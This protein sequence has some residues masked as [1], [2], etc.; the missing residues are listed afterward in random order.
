MSESSTHKKYMKAYRARKKQEQES[1][2]KEEQAW[3][4]RRHSTVKANG[5]PTTSHLFDLRQQLT[6]RSERIA[7]TDD[8]RRQKWAIEE[9]LRSRGELAPALK[10]GRIDNVILYNGYLALYQRLGLEEYLARVH[11]ELLGKPHAA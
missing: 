7:L 9:T 10:P 4:T 11:A 5:E 3:R 8:E 6:L 2:E 1:S